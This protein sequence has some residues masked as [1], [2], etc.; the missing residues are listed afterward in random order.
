VARTLAGLAQLAG[1][2]SRL[3]GLCSDKLQKGARHS[4]SNKT[5]NTFGGELNENSQFKMSMGNIETISSPSK[6]TNL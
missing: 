4:H 2:G 5:S 3:A 6:Y 1:F